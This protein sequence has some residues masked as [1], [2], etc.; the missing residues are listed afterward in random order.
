MSTFSHIW[1]SP[2]SRTELH[3][4]TIMLVTLRWIDCCD[5]EVRLLVCTPTALVEHCTYIVSIDILFWKSC[6]GSK[7]PVQPW[8]LFSSIVTGRYDYCCPVQMWVCTTAA[9]V[10][11]DVTRAKNYISGTLVVR[12]AVVLYC[13]NGCRST[14]IC[15]IN[16][17]G[18]KQ[19]HK[20]T[21]TLLFGHLPAC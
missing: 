20:H 17:F 9:G 13:K 8:W 1:L 18:L 15:K 11:M 3:C 10:G 14:L 6:S 19:I 7:W 5:C 21:E 16:Y 12:A 4:V 2:Q